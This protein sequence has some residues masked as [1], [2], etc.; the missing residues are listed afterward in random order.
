MALVL[1]SVVSSVAVVLVNRQRQI[2]QEQR[3][4]AEENFHE[5]RNAVDE[6]FTKV[7]EDTLLNQPGM[8]GLRKELLQKTLDYY[9]RFLEQRENDPSVQDEM[10][11]TQFRV[12]KIVEELE[13]PEKGL[14]YYESAK[15]RQEELLAAAPNDPQR[16]QAL[17]DTYNGIG[18]A[19]QKGQQFDEALKAFQR[20]REIRQQLVLLEPGEKVHQRALANTVMN[21]GCMEMVL[22]RLDDA[23]RDCELAQAS[24]RAQVVGGDDSSKLLGDLAKGYFD[25]ATLAKMLKHQSDMENF[26]RQALVGFEQLAKRDPRDQTAQY[27]LA[28]CNRR[29]GD[30]MMY[31][32]VGDGRPEEAMRCYALARDGLTRLVDQNPDVSEYKSLLAGV[33]MNMAL[34]QPAAA[35]MESFE[36]S[37]KLLSE[38]VEKYPDNPQFARDLAFML[39]PLAERQLVAG[40]VNAARAN[41]TTGLELLTRLAER[42]PKDA[43]IAA[44]LTKAREA[45]KKLKN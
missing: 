37:R 39:R 3:Q 43:G 24:R 45:L 34:H 23:Q 33:C 31:P 36:Q 9:K 28:L 8:Q 30:L 11:L 2:A 6:L 27:S 25:Q 26:L 41:L 17:G 44:E 38:L 32:A 12:G 15:Q 10:A 42:L 19:E 40:N 13:S 5:A 16:L 1:V 7:S 35:Q 20:A 18:R 14:P 4:I 22:G 21:I 29:L